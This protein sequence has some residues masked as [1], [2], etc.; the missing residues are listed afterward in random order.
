MGADLVPT[1]T[2]SIS[3]TA[4][5]KVQPRI[6][7]A[8]AHDEERAAG[9]EALSEEGFDVILAVDAMST[10]QFLDGARA[11]DAVIFDLSL[12]SE[13][14]ENDAALRALQETVRRSALF[15][16]VDESTLQMARRALQDIE[17]DVIP[18]KTHYSLVA[19]CIKRTLKRQEKRAETAAHFTTVDSSKASQK[20]LEELARAARVDVAVML[21]GA[22]GLEA[23]GYAQRLHM[24]SKRSHRVFRSVDCRMPGDA[25]FETLFGSSDLQDG[26]AQDGGV[27]A[28]AHGG[29]LFLD[30]LDEMP[31]KSQARLSRF[32]EEKELFVPGR[33]PVRVDIRL[34]TSSKADMAK[35]AGEERFRPDLLYRLAGFTVKLPLFKERIE[36]FSELLQRAFEGTL[37]GTPTLTSEAEAALKAYSW[38]GNDV[39]F[40]LVLQRATLLAQGDVVD[41]CHLP[42]E[43]SS[44]SAT[45]GGVE[46]TGPLLSLDDYEQHALSASLK[47]T[48]GN[49]THAA[50][51]L[52]I[53]R[54][55][56]YRK[57]RKYGVQI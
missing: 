8:C 38:P 9:Y 17:C 22:K 53:G 46:L 47:E 14:A 27:V 30:H 15:L 51:L 1:E 26:G 29:T 11:M 54:A 34:V 41:L 43:L 57:A 25:L 52:G 16:L 10:A 24:A 56:F 33:G 55:T 20:A 7:L 44:N 40:E 21:K 28:R 35:M 36:I 39:E 23:V 48:G 12:L 18:R 5:S 19:M 42:K 49:V 45:P 3:R 32:L 6:L 37:R 31:K 13:D 50:R 4:V 2:Q